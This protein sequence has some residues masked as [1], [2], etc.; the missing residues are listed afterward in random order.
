[1]TQ[2]FQGNK[3]FPSGRT[4]VGLR[5]DLP[6]PETKARPLFEQGGILYCTGTNSARSGVSLTFSHCIHWFLLYVHNPPPGG[7]RAAHHHRKTGPDNN[8]V[9]NASGV[10][11]SLMPAV[12]PC[13]IVKATC[14]PDQ[15]TTHFSLR[16]K[17]LL[18]KT[19]GELSDHEIGLRNFVGAVMVGVFLLLYSPTEG[20]EFYSCTIC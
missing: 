9:R 4:S 10:W 18:K 2:G 14:P 3:T 1:V 8:P 6:G 20:T 12:G 7:E 13:W 11:G 16:A 19:S 17:P 5:V 15:S